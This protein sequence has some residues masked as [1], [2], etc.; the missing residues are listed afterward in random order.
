M[1]PLWYNVV[2][3]NYTHAIRLK[4]ELLLFLLTSL[5]CLNGLGQEVQKIGDITDYDNFECLVLS[6]SSNIQ[7][8]YK[9]HKGNVSQ[10]K[11]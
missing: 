7:K 11:P 6:N 8:A 5:F 9:N 3:V 4:L 1:C 2:C 10:F